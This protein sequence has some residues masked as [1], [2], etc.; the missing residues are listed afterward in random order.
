MDG[1]YMENLKSVENQFVSVEICRKNVYLLVNPTEI[2]PFF[3]GFMALS[4]DFDEIEAE[5]RRKRPNC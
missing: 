2:R 4:T 5:F 3:S 1:N